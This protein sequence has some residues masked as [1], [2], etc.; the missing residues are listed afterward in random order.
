MQ[1]GRWYSWGAGLG[2]AVVL[3]AGMLAPAGRGAGVAL[4]ADA[5]TGTL[6]GVI[7][8]D[9]S[10][11]EM[12][13]LIAKGDKNTKDAEVCAADA[14][15]DESLV[16]DPASKGIANVFVYL[17]KAPAGYKA[18]PA[19]SEPVV[20]DQKNC[21]FIPHG[22]TVRVGQPVQVLSDDPIAH[23]T[24]T[25]NSQGKQFNHAVKANDRKGITLTYDKENRLPVKV[26]CDFHPW[27]VA[28][29]LVQDHPFM[30]VTDAK[31]Q[32]EITGLPPG[33][34]EFIVWHERKGYLNRKY[35]VSIKP[36]QTTEAKLSFAAKEFS[37]K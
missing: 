35:S 12:K 1:R 2:L 36:G 7:T 10:I 9:G 34:H 26:V 4:A 17:N 20:F 11:P 22:L 37:G 25:Q 8:F 13:P 30:A 27:M 23:N 29:H 6:K 21:K 16:V 5:N 33:D 32:F 15:P 14:V 18:A 19:P 24:H 31:G 3:G 28:Y